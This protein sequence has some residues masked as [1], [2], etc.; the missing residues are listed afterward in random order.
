MTRTL[1][2]NNGMDSRYWD[3]ML[4]GKETCFIL[5]NLHFMLYSFH[6]SPALRVIVEMSQ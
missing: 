1:G 3:K 6:S 2:E 5:A 4:Q